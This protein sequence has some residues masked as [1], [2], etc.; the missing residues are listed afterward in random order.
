MRKSV[1]TADELVAT[2]GRAIKPAELAKF[3]G[4]DR[5]TVI[6]YADRWGGVKVCP[7]CVPPEEDF[8]KVYDIS[9]GQDRVMLLAYLHLAGRR[10]EIFNLTWADIDF[11]DN[12]VRLWT[13]K[14]EGGNKESDWLPMTT[15]LREALMQWWQDRPVKDS[16]HVFL[17]LDHI[18][19]NEQFYGRPFTNRQH[20]MRRMC[21]RA[22]VK[23]FGFHAIRHLTAS[24]L[25]HKGYDVAVIQS[26]L[27]HKSTTTT[28][29]Y[30]KS[31]TRPSSSHGPVPG[32]YRRWQMK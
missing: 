8:W 18:P 30:L 1:A 5:R 4:L 6:K 11:G 9:E 19:V 15:E 13:N 10:K 25:Y 3:L 22:G 16:G 21:K 29:R 12:R 24:I 20:F 28:N 7:G 26:I 23:P 2:Y 31:Q 32:S 27:R 14:R 17:C